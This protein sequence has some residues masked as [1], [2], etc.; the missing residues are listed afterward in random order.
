MDQT[1][2]Y[3]IGFQGSTL[4]VAGLAILVFILGVTAM[5]FSLFRKVEQGTALV[6]SGLRG[7]SVSFTGMLIFPVI[8]KAE[9]MDIKLKHIEIERRGKEGLI[10][11]DNLRAD[12]Q[13][14]FFV[15]VNDTPQDVMRVATSVGCDRASNEQ[16]IKH[17]F[18]AKFSEALKTVGKRFEFE[19][20]YE[21]RVEF[22]DEIL[23]V[24]GTDLNGFVLDDVSIDFLEQTPLED[25]NPDNILDAEGIKKIRD[26]TAMWN[27]ERNLIE[28]DEERTIK[29]QDVEAQE[30]ILELERQLA[31]STAK[32]KREVETVQSREHAESERVRHEQWQLAE[33]ARLSAEEEIHVAEQNKE[34]SVIVAQRNKERTD[35]VELERVE[36]DRHLEE[37][38]RERLTSLKAI[39]RDKAIEIEQRNIQEV[40]RERVEVEKTVVEEKERIKDTE[41]FATAERSKKVAITAAE[42]NAQEELI[43]MI[44]EAEAEQEAAKLKADEQMYTR[45]KDA[46][47]SKAVAEKKAEEIVIAA[48]AEQEAAE[49]R[50][51]AMKVL[52][53]GTTAEAAAAGLGE[54]QVVR[55]TGEAQADV[56]RIQGDSEAAAINAKAE[57]MKLFDEVGRDHEE[58]KLRLDK[59]KQIELAEIDV[60]RDI[61]EQQALVLGEALKAAKI[62]I[63]GGDTEFFNRI[64]RSITNGKAV[65]RLMNNSET[66]TQVK[67][68]FFNGDPDYFREQLQ[69][70]LDQFGVSSEDL[71][72]LSISALLT[73]MIHDSGDSG[74]RTK[75]ESLLGA[76]QR[77]GMADNKA[78]TVLK[79]LMA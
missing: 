71:K 33:R 74:T 66:L 28:R 78:E 3:I 22:R 23:K 72:N 58:F 20:L 10:C 69:G 36:R 6:R 61:A 41:A 35:G 77:F 39:E 37:I 50:S 30:A 43:R 76:A 24:I 46:E 54:A 44:K 7:K 53:E 67:D 5:V 63:V 73:K 1:S 56:V 51:S 62:D 12:I 13:V 25:M 49:K 45:L 65:D 15:R 14:V 64:T 31:E 79:R 59:E 29:K 60:Q 47:A 9:L 38:E 27:K 26:R 18:S 52:A 42:Q 57:A 34:R 32:Q 75:L 55:A 17:L 21:N 4:V 68:T 8:D 11:K 70:W 2:I 48:E 40:I 16:Q 19:E